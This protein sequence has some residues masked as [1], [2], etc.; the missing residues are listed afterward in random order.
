MQQNPDR[1][2]DD[3][4]KAKLMQLGKGSIKVMASAL[5]IFAA[6]SNAHPQN[7]LVFVNGE[8]VTAI[9]VDQR[10]K[11]LQITGQKGVSRQDVLQ[12]LIDEKLKLAEAKRWGLSVEDKDVESSFSNMAGRMRLSGEQLTQSLAKSGI[13]ASTLKGRIRAELTWQQLVRSRY[14]SRL[15]LSDKE[16]ISALPDDQKDEAADASFDYVMR[17]ILF[18]VPPGSPVA[19]YESRRR[20]AEALRGRFRNCQEGLPMARSMRDVAVRDQVV[21]TSADLPAELRKIVDSIP[22]GQL[23]APEPTRHGIELFAICSKSPSKSD[24][25]GKRQA[26]DTLYSKRFEQESDRYLKQLR[27]AA[28]I[29][30]R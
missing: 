12:Q 23:T 4:K 6:V 21:R 2:G 16:V 18:L 7:V 20:D 3:V 30:R 10:S 29:E 1:S 26:R 14:Q 13:N 24:S 27:R 22:V 28:L 8:P 19:V 11:L 17:P 5:L 15:Q 9:D 25:P